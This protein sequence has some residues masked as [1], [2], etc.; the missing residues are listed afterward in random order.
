M[1]PVTHLHSPGAPAQTHLPHP[2]LRSSH[3]HDHDDSGDIDLMRYWS[4]LLGQWWIILLSLLLGLGAAWTHLSRAPRIYA[5][6]ATLELQ[7][8]SKKV[9][10]VQALMPAEMRGN[11]L[12]KTAEQALMASKL[13]L[14][15]IQ[16]T[17]LEKN[18]TFARP[19]PPSKAYEES[20]L[21]ELF[22]KKLSVN[23]RRGTRLIDITVEDED[24]KL[25]RSLAETLV[26][27]FLKEDLEQ[28]LSVTRASSQALENAAEK[29]KLKLQESEKKLQEYREKHHAV[30]L[31]ERQN[32]IVD[33]LKDLNFKST[34]ARELRLRLESDLA[35][36]QREKDAAP[37]NLLRLSSISSNSDV[38]TLRKRIQDKKSEFA[39]LKERYLELHPK[40][41][42]AEV[43]LAE[44]EDSLNA[45]I[46]KVAQQLVQNYEAAKNVEDKL[47]ASLHEQEKLSLQLHALSIPY[48]VLVREV[49]S[50]RALYA[51]V[52]NGL[53]EANAS[54]YFESSSMRLMDPPLV[55][56]RPIRPK[57]SKIYSTAGLFGILLGVGFVLV[58]DILRGTI[59][60]VSDIEHGFG[61]PVL[62]LVPAERGSNLTLRNVVHLSPASLQAEAFRFL[63]AS[64]GLLGKQ[65]EHRV[66]VFASAVG[67]EGKSF[68]AINYAASLAQQGL[69]TL[70]IDADLRKPRLAQ[71][72]IDGKPREEGLSDCLIGI[73]SLADTCQSTPFFNLSLLGAG[74]RAPNPSELLGSS[75]LREIVHEA[76]ESFD[77]VV[78]DTSPVNVFSDALL[79]SHAAQ[80][81]CLV[82]RANSTRR[83]AVKRALR[84]FYRTGHKPDGVVL[85]GVKLTKDAIRNLQEGWENL[86]ISKAEEA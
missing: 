34:A 35:V 6:T 68:C 47:A 66:I 39:V 25:A 64:V 27:R 23:L 80:S 48:N 11:E 16:E 60:S 69:S 49:E 55:A 59:R 77:R 79:V 9:S 45:A 51:S 46:L 44:L 8:D 18:P 85:N 26:D 56:S 2:A 62:A 14:N 78:I 75:S 52:L 42:Q 15:V 58:F 41:Q 31:E 32:I 73:S 5:S 54:N 30:S 7:N 72:L 43:Q 28:K 61:L 21:V 38:D 3:A 17:G 19:L 10:A 53:K 81:V 1:Q 71:I 22:S 65:S 12:L 86:A 40:Y 20:E 63:R 70:L 76:L 24:P 57:P 33:K 36:I 4:L 13:I 50:D 29:L 82:I 84:L 74:H 83:R 37:Q 67:D